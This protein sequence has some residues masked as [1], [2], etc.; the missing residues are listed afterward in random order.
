MRKVGYYHAHFIWEGTQIIPSHSAWNSI[1]VEAEYEPQPFGLHMAMPA[2]LLTIWVE[3]ERTRGSLTEELGSFPAVK[4]LSF[5]FNARDWTQGL[6]HGAKNIAPPPKQ[7]CFLKWWSAGCR[8]E[9]WMVRAYRRD[10]RLFL[11]LGLEKSFQRSST[12]PQHT[13]LASLISRCSIWGQAHWVLGEEHLCFYSH[14]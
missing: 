4:S 13:L 1:D 8:Q 5:C 7:L 14:F 2:I 9:T 10:R 12:T 11:S 3:S 6:A